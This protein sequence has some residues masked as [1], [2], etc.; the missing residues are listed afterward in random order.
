MGRF[1]KNR[2]PLKSISLS[3]DSPLLTCISNDFD[4]ENV[5]SRQIEGLGEKGDVLIALSTSGNSINI[6]R[7]INS[8]KKGDDNNLNPWQRRRSC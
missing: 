5:F 8:A 6:E 1:K 3:A 7:V 4:Y 2:R